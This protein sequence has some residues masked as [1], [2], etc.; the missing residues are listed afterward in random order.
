MKKL[1]ILHY[2]IQNLTIAVNMFLCF[3]DEH[4]L[5]GRINN[6]INMLLIDH[7]AF[8]YLFQLSTNLKLK[9]S[10]FLFCLILQPYE[11]ANCQT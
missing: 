8:F 9:K 11:Y 2:C 10:L 6:D 1:K 5:D 3:L 7:F 4:V